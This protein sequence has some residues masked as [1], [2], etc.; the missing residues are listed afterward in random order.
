MVYLES[1][2]QQHLVGLSRAK[3]F[4]ADLEGNRCYAQA[5]GVVDVRSLLAELFGE[6]KGTQRSSLLSCLTRAE[7]RRQ[8]QLLESRGSQAI[9]LRIGGFTSE[10]IGREGLQ[11][12]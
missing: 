6:S 4:S 12:Q 5:L 1:K 10:R 9:G 3:S 7:P 8:A 11:T 2:L